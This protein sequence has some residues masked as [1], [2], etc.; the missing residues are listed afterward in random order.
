MSQSELRLLREVVDLPTAP[1]AEG[2]VAGFVRGFVKQYSQL[3]LRADAFG[4]LL[5]KY[6]PKRKPR[7]RA[8][9]RPVLFAAHMDHPGFVAEEMIDGRHVQAA[10]HGGVQGR[11][12]PSQKI[13]FYVDGRWIPGQ[14]VELIAKPSAKR[15]PMRPPAS[16]RRTKTPAKPA[17]R[18]AAAAD[19][20]PKAVIAR[21]RAPVPRGAAGTWDIPDAIIR[22]NLLHARVTDDLSGLAAVLGALHEV[23]ERGSRVPCYALFT[24]AE[25]VGFGGA[26]A[27]VDAGTVPQRALVVVVENS[28]ALPGIAL[29]DGPVLRVGDKASVFAPAA[30]AY[31]R[32]VAEKLADRDK[33]FRFQR[34]LMDGGTCEATAYGYYGCDV[35]CICLPL[36]NYH[37]MDA[38]RGRIAP[39]CIDV[40]DYLN[41]VRWFVAL[42]EDPPLASFDG[43]DPVLAKRL[44]SLLMSHRRRLLDSAPAR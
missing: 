13:K 22:G 41:L 25:E 38:E 36:L 8:R 26:L 37:N 40:R 23:C 4:N 7:S 3:R 6:V 33:A 32:L 43:T 10:W 18:Q 1:F 11:F 19:P 2:C 42:A 31:C 27:A 24:R 30:T 17:A 34:K 39:E 5:V 16:G 35:T 21:V 15:R 44:A 20:P 12:F 28:K 14:V 29:G 9:T